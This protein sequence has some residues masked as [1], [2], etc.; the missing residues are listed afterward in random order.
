MS[1]D[2]PSALRH[3]R[4]LFAFWRPFSLAAFAA[5]HQLACFLR[6]AKAKPP[7]HDTQ[8]SP[9]IIIEIGAT[10]PQCATAP[11]ARNPIGAE[12]EGRRRACRKGACRRLP[13]GRNQSP[14]RRSL[15][16]LPQPGTICERTLTSATEPTC[17]IAKGKKIRDAVAGFLSSS[18][19]EDGRN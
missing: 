4:K 9:P 10:E 11:L 14:C 1:R 3:L 7:R 6:A 2:P 15:A 17:E 18:T 19:N 13:D 12:K 16:T 5:L 8:D